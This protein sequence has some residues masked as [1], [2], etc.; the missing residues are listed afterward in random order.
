MGDGNAPFKARA[1]QQ[2]SGDELRGTRGVDSDLTAF[3]YPVRAHTKG[4]A[5]AIHLHAELA[6]R[7][8]SGGHGAG[9]GLLVAV[10]KHG[11]VRQGSYRWDKA[12]DRAGQAAVHRGTLKRAGGDVDILA[13]VLEAHAHRFQGLFHQLRIAGDQ[14]RAQ[15][16]RAIGQ[17]CK[18][19]GAVGNRLR[20]RHVLGP[21][22]GACRLRGG[23]RLRHIVH[24]R[25]H[26]RKIRSFYRVPSR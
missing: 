24:N 18:N 3:R 12:H 17:R 9:V 4:Q 14:R 19:E 23:P 22:N 7:V 26:V 10:D 25:G 13:F 21:R 1:G 11:A 15:G 8:Q 20:A 16:R 2:E 6:Q 5:I